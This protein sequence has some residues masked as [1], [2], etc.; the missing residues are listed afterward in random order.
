[1]ICSK[2][3]L[4]KESDCFRK[5]KSSCKTCNAEYLKQWKKDNPDKVSKYK[6]P[7]YSKERY[8]TDEEYRSKRLEAGKRYYRNNYIKKLISGAK[9]RSSK[10]GLPFDLTE[11]DIIIPEFCPVFGFKLEIS[12]GQPS[13]NSPSIDKIVPELGYVKT[14]IRIISNLANRMKSNA[15]P[16]QLKTF[17]EWILKDAIQKFT[18]DNN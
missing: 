4:D 9:L 5:G 12:N 15:T 6:K 17:A 2:C 18:Q 11:E 1:M 14:N 10:L 16:E 13:D 7:E 8:L 3:N